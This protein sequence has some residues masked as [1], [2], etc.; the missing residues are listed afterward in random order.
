MTAPAVMTAA[1]LIEN[2][3]I[4]RWDPNLT[5]DHEDQGYQRVPDTPR[6]RKMAKYAI[7]NIDDL[8]IPTTILLSA[9][10]IAL[11]YNEESRELTYSQSR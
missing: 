7:Q 10:G 8:L 6:V 5:H 9:R 2:T 11:R 4:D 3:T 1:D